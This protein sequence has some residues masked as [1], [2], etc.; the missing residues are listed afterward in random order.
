MC[1]G[2]FE[3]GQDAGSFWKGAHP[4]MKEWDHKEENPSIALKVEAAVLALAWAAGLFATVSALV[5]FS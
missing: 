4:Q 2:R 3:K 1:Y 5:G